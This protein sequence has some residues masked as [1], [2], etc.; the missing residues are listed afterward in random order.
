MVFDELAEN[1]LVVVADNEDFFNL[2]DLGDGAEAVFYDR[3]AG[4]FEERLGGGQRSCFEV[5]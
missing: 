5:M 4:D 3:V 2:G 1:G